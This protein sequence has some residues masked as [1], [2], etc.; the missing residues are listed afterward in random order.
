M[1]SFNNFIP[2][3]LVV[4]GGFQKM[5]SD[6][7]NYNSRNELV[8]TNKGISA[9]VYENWI[10]RVPSENDMRSIT[11]DTAIQIYKKNYWDKGKGSQMNTQEVANVLID[12]G[13]NAGMSRAGKLVQN[14]LNNSFGK[15]VAVDGAIGNQTILAMNSVEQVQLQ[16][17]IVTA[18]INYYESLRNQYPEFINGWLNRV[19]DFALEGERMLL[20]YK[21]PLGFIFG[22]SALILGTFFFLKY[23]K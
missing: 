22:I 13:V 21:R 12:H 23:K 6:T 17:A 11:K 7:G 14:V 16:S 1:A 5:G 19:N 4:E 18:R 15:N 8:G 10:N 2:H 9:P 20:E 3:L